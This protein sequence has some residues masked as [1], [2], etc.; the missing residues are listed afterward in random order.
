VRRM[1]MSSKT[2][3]TYQKL[4]AD[5]SYTDR[6]PSVAYPSEVLADPTLTLEQKRAI[7]ASWLSDKHA[8]PDAPRWRLLENGAFVDIEDI[9][10]ALYALDDAEAEEVGAR[11]TA[12]PRAQKRPKRRQR[13]IGGILK[14]SRRYD[15]DD[16]P[17]APTTPPLP[18][19]AKMDLDCSTGKLA[20]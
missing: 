7:L 6:V 13:W 17:P 11:Q 10:Q 14:R 3:L 1:E 4:T 20:V 9:Q 8:V 15:D 18:L 16:P 2:I 19:R 12:F 5:E